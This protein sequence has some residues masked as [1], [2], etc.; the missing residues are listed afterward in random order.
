MNSMRSKLV[1]ILI[2]LIKFFDV[3]LDIKDRKYVYLNK[4]LSLQNNSEMI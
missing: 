4:S 2:F 1:F 3:F